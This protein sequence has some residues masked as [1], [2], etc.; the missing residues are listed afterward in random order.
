MLQF[1]TEDYIQNIITLIGIY[2]VDQGILSSSPAENTGASYENETFYFSAY[3]W[4]AEDASE[5]PPNFWYKLTN[6][7]VEWHKHL[8]RSTKSNQQITVSEAFSI[9][10]ECLSSIDEDYSSPRT[11]SPEFIWE[12]TEPEDDE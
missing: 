8:G 12:D 6:Y 5:V 4:N 2:L 1:D 9:L 3:D 10:W 7:Q 11:E